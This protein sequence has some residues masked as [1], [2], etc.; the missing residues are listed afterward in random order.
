MTTNV[1]NF[2]STIHVERIVNNDTF[3]LLKCFSEPLQLFVF[4]NEL[5]VYHLYNILNT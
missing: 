3:K 2:K 4:E 1:S 5:I